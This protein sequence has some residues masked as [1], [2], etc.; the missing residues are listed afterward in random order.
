MTSGG[1]AH[2]H[3]T[4]TIESVSQIHEILGRRGPDHPLV[5]VIT[6]S[7]HAPL[8]IPAGMMNQRVASNLYAISLKQGHECGLKYGR[9]TYDFQ[10]GS[11]MFLAP[12]QVV[13]PI[14]E[15]GEIEA[16]GESW[17][18]AFH[19]D[20]LRTSPLAAKMREYSFFGYESHEALH[21]SDLEQQTLTSIVK[22]IEG[23]YTRGLD[24]YS[25]ELI[26]SHIQLLL[27]YCKRY[28]GRQFTLRS[29]ANKDIVAR[30]ERLLEQYFESDKP[31]TQGLPSVR[32]CARELGYSPD[33]LS[34]LL[35]KETGKTAREHIQYFLI[36]KAKTR[37]LGSEASIS[38][39][40][41]ALGFEHPQHFS[42]LFRSKTGMSPGE[43]RH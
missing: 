27:T 43:Y 6:A 18:L 29:V 12:G 19:P 22:T 1:R 16:E 8:R 4:F 7:W 14:T 10:E 2:V 40:A 28:Y 41:Y 9:Q 24:T 35:R 34:D 15:A 3:D 32:T 26:V 11:V 31:A 30:F 21:L 5:S 39:I 37:L 13:T 36:E 33:Y 17:T 42:K 20:L 23:E 25:Q 38:E